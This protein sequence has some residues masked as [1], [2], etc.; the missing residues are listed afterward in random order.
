MIK[1]EYS[2]WTDSGSIRKPAIFKGFRTDKL[3]KDVVPEKALSPQKEQKIIEA[4]QELES[5]NDTRVSETNNS[6]KKGLKSAIKK[7]EYLNEDSNWK[8]LDK[9]EKKD[10]NELPVGDY[11]VEV[12]DLGKV[13]WKEPEVK[14]A[15][16]LS[17]YASISDYIIPYLK[18]RP[19]SVYIKNISPTAPGLYIKDFEGRAPE[20]ADVLQPNASEI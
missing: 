9:I 10:P 17:Y 5:S 1:V 2:T 13:L 16:L 15:D 8:E 14:K 20:Y 11:K 6:T 18:D 12:Y 4:P 7:Q 19:L 3:P